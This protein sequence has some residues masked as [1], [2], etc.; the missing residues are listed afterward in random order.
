[1]KTKLIT[2]FFYKLQL[3]IFFHFEYLLQWK[4]LLCTFAQLKRASNK[5]M[6][7]NFLVIL[8]LRTKWKFQLLQ[9][10]YNCNYNL[11]QIP[12]SLV[13]NNKNFTVSC[14]QTVLVFL[15][16]KF[17]LLE[18]MYPKITKAIFYGYIS[19]CIGYKLLC[20]WRV[21][22]HTFAKINFFSPCYIFILACLVFF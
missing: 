2:I 4:K 13:F 5:K 22:Y 1:M 21:C 15:K 8:F 20:S 9:K 17:V 7:S 16:Q 19:F 12:L 14:P 18:Y 3:I 6:F 10:F 11:T